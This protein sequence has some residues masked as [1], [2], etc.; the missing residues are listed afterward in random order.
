LHKPLQVIFVEA[1]APERA[2]GAINVTV[3]VP[4]QPLLSVTVSVYVVPGATDPHR[5]VGLVVPGGF[6][7]T[8]GDQFSVG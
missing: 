6:G 8:D 1:T 4:T 2:V 5:P 3:P 7:A